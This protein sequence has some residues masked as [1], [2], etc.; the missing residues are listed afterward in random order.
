MVMGGVGVQGGERDAAK[1]LAEKSWAAVAA[2]LKDLDPYREYYGGCCVSVYVCVCVWGVK[3]PW[4][5]HLCA[6]WRMALRGLE[7]LG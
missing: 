1:A 5:H 2:L 3:A 4:R 6:D 7:L